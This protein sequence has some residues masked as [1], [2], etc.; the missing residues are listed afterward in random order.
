MGGERDQSQETEVLFTVL[1]QPLFCALS[2]AHSPCPL[3]RGSQ[4]TPTGQGL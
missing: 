4:E 2:V 3:L 1:P